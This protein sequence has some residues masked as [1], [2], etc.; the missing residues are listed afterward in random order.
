MPSRIKILFIST[1]FP[2]GVYPTY[3]TAYWGAFV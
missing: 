2:F 1:I 3:S